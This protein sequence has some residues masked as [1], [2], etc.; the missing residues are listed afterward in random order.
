MDWTE[1]Y[2][3]VANPDILSEDFVPDHVF[4]RDVQI[5]E[6]QFCL[7]PILKRR[8]PTHAWLCGKSGAGKTTIAKYLLEKIQLETH[9]KGTYVNCWEK[10]SFFAILQEILNN[11]NPTE[12][13]LFRFKFIESFFLK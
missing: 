12:K 7:S 2:G 6:L 11:L 13:I 4:A 9:I 8:K 1:D 10:N 5:R 3:I